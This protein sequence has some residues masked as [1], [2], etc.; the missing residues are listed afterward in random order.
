VSSSTHPL[1]TAVSATPRRLLIGTILAPLGWLALTSA[2]GGATSSPLL[3]LGAVGVAAA[4]GS[5]SLATYVPGPGSGWRPIWGCGPCSVVT[6]MSLPAAAI[7]LNASP[8][9]ASAAVLAIFVNGLGLAQ[10]LRDPKAC[11]TRPA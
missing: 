7:I 5:A 8:W 6:L 1:V 3:W 2:G 9:E 11:P 4:L 10:R